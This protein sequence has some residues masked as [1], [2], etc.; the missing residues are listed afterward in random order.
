MSDR[1]IPLLATATSGLPVEYVVISGPANLSS[2]SL[3]LIAVGTVVLEARQPGNDQFEAAPP[4]VQFF[5]VLKGVQTI[6]FADL[7]PVRL[8]SGPVA[9]SATA[10]SGLPVQFG[11]LSGPTTLSSN[12][13]TPVAAGEVTL[14][15]LQ[16]GN[17]N[18]EPAGFVEKTLRIDKALQTI[19]FDPPA[20][21][22]QNAGPIRLDA[23]ASSGL[24]VR[25]LILSGPALLAGDNLTILD[26]GTISIRAFQ[27]GDANHEPAPELDRM[28]TI[29]G[30]TRPS[31]SLR[32]EPG[33]ITL[34]WSTNQTGFFVEQSS[35]VR[36]PVWI[37]VNDS[38]SISGEF[39]IL[40]I[41]TAGTN[42]F[43]R[44]NPQ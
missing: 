14:I 25:Y 28:I 39:F 26:Q 36:A 19:Q 33:S 42:S 29:I 27:P 6:T 9:L 20:E 40:R 1:S 31:L 30:P 17:E 16:S 38:T 23:I 13:L 18:Y 11:I 35:S 34:Q 24:P 10:S 5:N 43:F 37:R 32:H 8:K 44:L 2:N 21:I 4:L 15:A 12:L 7:P 22:P 3:N 41:T